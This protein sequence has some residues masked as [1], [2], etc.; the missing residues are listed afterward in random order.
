MVYFGRHVFEENKLP[1]GT[2]QEQMAEEQHLMY[3]TPYIAPTTFSYLTINCESLRRYTKLYSD[4]HVHSLINLY[5][6]RLMLVYYK[7]D[8]GYMPILDMST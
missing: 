8:L 6:H 1:N 7:F 5:L 2:P 3:I 4:W